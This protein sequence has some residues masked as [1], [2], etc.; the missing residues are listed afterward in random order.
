MKKFIVG[1]IIISSFLSLSACQKKQSEAKL[2]TGTWLMEQ[3]P[4]LSYAQIDGSSKKIVEV[5]GAKKS[6]ADKTLIFTKTQRIYPKTAT[7]Q[8]N[9]V[10]YHYDAK[11]HEIK[12]SGEM[13]GTEKVS[14]DSSGNEL[15][16][17]YSVIKS[18]VTF[19]RKNS[20]QAKFIEKK[21]A[22]EVKKLETQIKP[23]NKIWQTKR[24]TF[25]QDFEEAIAGNWSNVADNAQVDLTRDSP[26]TPATVEIG[27]P[28][29]AVF[30]LSFHQENKK[31]K[32][33]IYFSNVKVK[34]AYISY[35]LD[36]FAKLFAVKKLDAGHLKILKSRLETLTFRDIFMKLGTVNLK[37]ELPEQALTQTIS[38]SAYE[39]TVTSNVTKF[40]KLMFTSSSLGEPTLITYL[41]P[42]V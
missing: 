23:I 5:L 1:I 36:D 41:S 34:N 8:A 17:E 16:F 9:K 26:Q 28:K 10:S 42:A 39:T 12:Y 24:A 37:Y 33:D 30:A 40:E 35:G 38:V 15:S 3:K 22:A 29:S 13:M 25:R 6:T 4:T 31:S 27:K 20:P 18:K 11:K 2:L 14:F 32:K 21:N 19:Y 7:Q